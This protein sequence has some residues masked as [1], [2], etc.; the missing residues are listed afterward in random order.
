[1]DAL[2]VKDDNL[3]CNDGYYMDNE[4]IKTYNILYKYARKKGMNGVDAEDFRGWAIIKIIER[5]LG[6]KTTP[7]FEQLFIDYYRESKTNKQRVNNTNEH[8]DI[9]FATKQVGYNQHKDADANEITKT[10]TTVFDSLPQK[11]R[12]VYILHTV[13]QYK[14]TEIAYIFGVHETRIS[15]LIKLVLFFIKTPQ[16]QIPERLDFYLKWVTI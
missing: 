11:L 14:S 10:I 2:L 16:I 15:Q 8:A 1:M 5:K 6:N 13:Y 12:V 7:F 4:F 3:N 9:E